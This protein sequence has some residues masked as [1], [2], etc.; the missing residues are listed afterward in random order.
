[1]QSPAATRRPVDGRWPDGVKSD[2]LMMNLETS[3]APGEFCIF[4][5]ITAYSCDFLLSVLKQPKRLP[6]FLSLILLSSRYKDLKDYM[7]QA[8]EVTYADAHKQHK[9]EGYVID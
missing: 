7:R 9:N 4:L 6:L 3:H 5:E 2:A 1:M 8:G